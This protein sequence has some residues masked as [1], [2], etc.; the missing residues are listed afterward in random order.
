[1]PALTWKPRTSPSMRSAGK[2]PTRQTGFRPCAP[3][4]GFTSF[5]WHELN[6]DDALTLR[7]EGALAREIEQFLRRSLL[8][9]RYFQ[10]D[11]ILEPYYPVSMCIHSTGIGFQVI[12]EV[13]VGDDK[14]TSS[15]IPTRISWIRWKSWK[16]CIIPSSRATMTRKRSAFPTRRR[17]WA[18]QCP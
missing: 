10:A 15:R 2:E 8:Q 3:S 18:T 4:C 14:T 13:L 16:S 17:C 6:I 1:M 5:P 11:M 7:C 9:W 12:E